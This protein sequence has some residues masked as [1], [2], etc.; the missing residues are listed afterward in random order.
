[1][2]QRHKKLRPK[3]SAVLGSKGNINKNFRQTVMLEI[4]KQTGRSSFRIRKMSGRMLYRSQPLPK[5][6][7][8]VT[9]S[10]RTIDVGALATL[11]S[12]PALTGKEDSDTLVGHNKGL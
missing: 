10:L 12:F 2:Q 8:K 6:R 7:N 5:W 3:R 11:G 4:V 9:S 1:M